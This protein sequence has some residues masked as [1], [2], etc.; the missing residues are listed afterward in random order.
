MTSF[1]VRPMR[2]ADVAIRLAHPDAGATGRRFDAIA[3]TE[4]GE[5]CLI[6]LAEAMHAR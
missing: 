4:S 5:R 6:A 2:E 1:K 3:T